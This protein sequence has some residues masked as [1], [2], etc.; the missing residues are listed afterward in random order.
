MLSGETMGSHARY[1]SRSA[2]AWLCRKRNLAAAAR[3]GRL[4]R[5]R[6]NAKWP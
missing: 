2:A 1:L 6:R 3:G 5:S 4:G